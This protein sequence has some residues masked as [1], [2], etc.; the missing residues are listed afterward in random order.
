LKA[1]A[2]DRYDGAVIF[3]FGRKTKYRPIAGGGRTRRRCP[4]CRQ[5]AEIV[6]CERVHT[7]EAYFVGLFDARK[8]VWVCT[9][10]KEEIEA[11][12][13]LPEGDD[14]AAR[15]ELE[16]EERRAARR[17][18]LADKAEAVKQRV[19]DELAALKAKIRPK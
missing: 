12:D 2:R 13:E 1:R 7:Y 11:A 4:E 15:A 16:A 3:L 19:E 10:C 14:A 17:K 5:D 18:Q 9:S 6:A 8:T